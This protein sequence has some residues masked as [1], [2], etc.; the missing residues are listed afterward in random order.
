MSSDQISFISFGPGCK[1]H[2]LYSFQ[3]QPSSEQPESNKR[4]LGPIPDTTNFYLF[5]FLVICI[6]LTKFQKFN[7]VSLITEKYFL[8]NFF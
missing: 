3:A 4:K 8:N 7:L 2:G 6:C 1:E 5:I